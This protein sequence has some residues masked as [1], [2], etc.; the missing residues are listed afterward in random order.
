MT[1]Y[2]RFILIL[3]TAVVLFILPVQIQASEYK[4]LKTPEYKKVLVCT[5]FE[6]CDFITRDLY[7]TI[8]SV[9]SRAKIKPTISNSFVFQTNSKGYKSIRE[10]LDQELIE[11]QKVFIHIYGKCIEYDSIHIYQ[12]AIHFAKIDKKYSNALL[13]SSPEHN[14]MG[15]DKYYG[16]KNAFKKI[17]EDAVADYLSANINNPPG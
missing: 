11:N 8:R 7:K 15:A 14:V 10:L 6:E 9:L 17:M 16:I 13:Y 2:S 1:T 12:F 5:D 3:F 4:W